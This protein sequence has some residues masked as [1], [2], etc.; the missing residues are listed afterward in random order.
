MPTTASAP[1]PVRTPQPAA[2]PPSL[3]LRALFTW[4]AVFTA[5]SVVQQTLGPY[6]T[7]LPTA[8]RTLVITGV[9]VPTVVYGAVPALLGA[10]TALLRRR[11]E[12]SLP[13][14]LSVPQDP[15]L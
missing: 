11:R 12:K 3:H 10:R 9:V 4:A 8:L 7:G 2:A 15:A 1:T 14:R 5:L 6:L 13:G